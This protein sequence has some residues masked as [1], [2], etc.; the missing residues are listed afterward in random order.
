[1]DPRHLRLGVLASTGA[2]ERVA[3]FVQGVCAVNKNVIAVN[4]EATAV[5]AARLRRYVSPS[6]NRRGEQPCSG[7]GIVGCGMTRFHVRAL[8]GI[9]GTQVVALFDHLRAVRRSCKE[10]QGKVEHRCDTTS[11]P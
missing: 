11:D 7:I 4:A 1:M 8:N 6:N 5:S 9:P 3:V 10:V 2:A